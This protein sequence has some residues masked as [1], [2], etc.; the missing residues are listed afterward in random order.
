LGH[1]KQRVAYDLSKVKENV[2][3]KSLVM[4]LCAAFVLV[5]FAHIKAQP[6]AAVAVEYG[7][8]PRIVT[9]IR[10]LEDAVTYMEAAPHDFGGHR[11]AAI[12]ASRKA[13][14][15]LKKALAF[16]ARRDER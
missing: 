1:R 3:K 8:H 13:I 6:R 5:P 14:M 4:L 11:A 10:D 12:A 7:D 15:Q 2:M 16:R 9:A